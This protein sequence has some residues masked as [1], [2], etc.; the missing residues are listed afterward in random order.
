MLQG[1][2]G[3]GSTHGIPISA[4]GALTAHTGVLKP[5]GESSLSQPMCFPDMVFALAAPFAS[6]H[7]PWSGDFLSPVACLEVATSMDKMDFSSSRI[8][9][10]R[11]VEEESSTQMNS[12][13]AV[14]A[15]ITGF[16]HE[17]GEQRKGFKWL[18]L[19][20]HLIIP[21]FADPFN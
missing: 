13:L 5:L 17:K 7:Q 4:V 15:N 21:P 11:V 3:V 16:H 20:V 9:A 8:R 10:R 12:H 1:E 19:P 18:L 14:V 2:A 6:H